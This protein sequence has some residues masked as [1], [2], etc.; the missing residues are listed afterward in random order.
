MMKE[1]RYLRYEDIHLEMPGREVQISSARMD[2]DS[3]R[4]CYSGL[5]SFPVSAVE[6]SD[7]QMFRVTIQPIQFSANPIDSDT[8]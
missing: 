8:L 5:Q 7:I 6:F 1:L 2:R 4:I 3:A